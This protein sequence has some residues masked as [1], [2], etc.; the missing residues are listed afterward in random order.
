M[1]SPFPGMDPYVEDPATWPDFHHNLLA[2]IR[3]ALNA[4]M[5]ARYVAS[6]DQYV[7]LEARDPDTR[8]AD[9]K[10]DVLISDHGARANGAVALL[11][12]PAYVALP[13]QP[14]QRRFVQ[15]TD[16]RERR[17]VT[18]IEVLSP[19]NKSTHREAY[20]EKRGN[21]LATNTNLVEY[22]LLRGGETLPMGTP[23]PQLRDYYVMVSQAGQPRGGL[24]PFGLR[25][26]I[27]VIPIPLGPSD[28]PVSL[29]LHCLMQMVYD[30]GRYATK[31]DYTRPPVPR[32]RDDDAQW[33]QQLIAG[34]SSGGRT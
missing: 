3:I 1:P 24:W 19:S 8:E 13:T 10:P 30:E 23:A 18:V 31:I 26:P 33:A 15:I 7:W 29:D 28:A 5:P 22:D 27:P 12:A 11:E 16:H 6:V 14:R 2:R 17:V 21:Y 20:L 9:G 32:L 34:R 25:E 4:V